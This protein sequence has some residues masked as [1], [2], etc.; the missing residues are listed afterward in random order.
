MLY[1]H[2]QEKK[3]WTINFGHFHND[4]DVICKCVSI[5]DN[6]NAGKEI[7]NKK[8]MDAEGLDS[9]SE[10]GQFNHSFMQKDGE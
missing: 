5:D 8:T 7:D 4:E 2:I 10:T 1:F 9:I 6:T 3:R